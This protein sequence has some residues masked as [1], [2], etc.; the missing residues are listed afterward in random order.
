MALWMGM[1][2]GTRIRSTRIARGCQSME[3]KDGYT[4]RR[5]IKKYRAYMVDGENR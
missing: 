4:L 2:T 5:M 3:L 1:G